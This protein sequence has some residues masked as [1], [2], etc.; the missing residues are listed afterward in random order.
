VLA[1]LEARLGFCLCHS[2]KTLLRFFSLDPVDD[3]FLIDPAQPGVGGLTARGV[4]SDRLSLIVLGKFRS[5][6][7]LSPNTLFCE[8][9][10][11]NSGKT[12]LGLYNEVLMA[13]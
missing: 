6:T 10:D 12:T 8:Q 3:R 1:M 9:H 2:L 13:D 4:R 7:I 11:S 5:S